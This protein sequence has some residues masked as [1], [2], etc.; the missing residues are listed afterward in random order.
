M[1]DKVGVIRH[2]LKHCSSIGIVLVG[3]ASQVTWVF[4][5]GI[6]WFEESGRRL[7][8]RKLGTSYC[9]CLINTKS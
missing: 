7:I 8:S 6:E 9:Q 4:V 3:L 2:V 5:F 1:E